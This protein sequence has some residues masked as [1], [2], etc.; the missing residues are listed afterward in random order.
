MDSDL[1]KARLLSIAEETAGRHAS[2]RHQRL[3][4]HRGSLTCMLSMYFDT[5]HKCC[6]GYLEWNSFGFL[7]QCMSF[8]RATLKLAGP[9]MA[10]K[11]SK[12][13][14]RNCPTTSS[15]Y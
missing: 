4:M 9:M 11:L 15:T 6:S 7:L 10:T 14:C 8:T 3:E 5:V 12:S 1:Q 2:F 13:H